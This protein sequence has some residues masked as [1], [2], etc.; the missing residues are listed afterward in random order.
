M[1]VIH[2]REYY[3][4]IMAG[5]FPRTGKA[6]QGYIVNDCVPQEGVHDT[7]HPD[8]VA[9]EIRNRMIEAAH[10]F[11]ATAQRRGIT[12][13]YLQLS[14]GER[15]EA[16]GQRREDRTLAQKFGVDTRT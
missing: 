13:D 14:I 15:H 3:R 6:P 12:I 2:S 9:W 16:W 7:M 4:R 5:E 8:Y 10:A 11:F 1:K